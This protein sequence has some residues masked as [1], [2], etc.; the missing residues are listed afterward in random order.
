MPHQDGQEAAAEQE[1]DDSLAEMRATIQQVNR[2]LGPEVATRWFREI[3]QRYGERIR[4]RSSLPASQ[5]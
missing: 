5:S 3:P 2:Q 1:A 4:K